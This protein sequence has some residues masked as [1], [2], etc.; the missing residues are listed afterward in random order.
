MSRIRGG[1]ACGGGYRE[2]VVAAAAALM[3]TKAVMVKTC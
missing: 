3:V 2:E 1:V